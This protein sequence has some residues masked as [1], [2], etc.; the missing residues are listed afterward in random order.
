MYAFIQLN[1]QHTHKRCIN[2][3]YDLKSVPVKAEAYV[4]VNFI[5]FLCFRLF[6]ILHYMQRV[7]LAQTVTLQFF[8]YF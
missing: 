6:R 5:N 7:L 1:I 2:I 3:K 8:F 4:H